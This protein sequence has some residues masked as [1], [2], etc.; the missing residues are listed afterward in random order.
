M[1]YAPDVFDG[2]ARVRSINIAL[3]R[4]NVY[5]WEQSLSHVTEVPVNV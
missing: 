5:F 1:S 3:L 2:D 4:Q